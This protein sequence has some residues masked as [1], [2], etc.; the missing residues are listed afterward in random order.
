MSVGVIDHAAGTRDLRHM[1]ALRREAPFALVLTIIGAAAMAGIPPLLG[2]VSKEKVLT[3]MLEYGEGGAG[4][5]AIDS[6]P[7]V[8]GG[9]A[10][11]RFAFDP[12]LAT[13]HVG[14][15]AGSLPTGL[16]PSAGVPDA[17]V[18]AAWPAVFAVLGETR[19]PSGAG[20]VVEG[21]L[22]L[23]HL[24]HGVRMHAALPSEAADLVVVALSLIHI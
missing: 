1:P 5:A 16:A 3:A 17:L 14:V 7:E 15:T 21:L 8:V 4:G 11:A 13:D 23:V 22:D 12:T 18:G 2:F 24:D 6:L 9:V 19:R 20:T 10:R